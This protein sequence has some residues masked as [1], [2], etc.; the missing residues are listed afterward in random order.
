[1]KKSYF[2]FSMVVFLIGISCSWFAIA[3]TKD[4]P[5][6]KK[7][8]QQWTQTFNMEQRTFSSTGKNPY[9]ILEPGHQRILETSAD[10]LIITVLKDTKMVSGVET[11][12]VE[13][14]E[15]E[16]GQLVEVSR[17][18]FAIC[19]RTNDVFYFGEEVDMYKDGKITGHGGAWLA[20]QSGATPGVIMPGTFLLGSRYYQ[21]MAE[22]VAMDRGENTEMDLTIETPAGTFNHC[23]KVVETSPLESGKSIK[24]YAPGI[25]L[26]VDDTF[27]LVE[28]K[29]GV[30]E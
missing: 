16:D 12:V 3:A 13:E 17:N 30:T 10:K 8:Q 9:F 21:E 6:G 4:N 2:M 7:P 20:G 25:G 18:F 27:K 26:V 1:M 14:R 29:T 24:I 11:R 23:V 19:T 22:D 5:S 28:V 15:W